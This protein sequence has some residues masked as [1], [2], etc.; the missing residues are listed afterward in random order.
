M[1]LVKAAV[2][3][4]VVLGSC[5][6]MTRLILIINSILIEGGMVRF[7]RIIVLLKILTET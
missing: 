6:V 3:I 1:N 4:T 5:W 7:S 2:I